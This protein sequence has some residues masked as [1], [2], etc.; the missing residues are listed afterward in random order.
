VLILFLFTGSLPKNL[1]P[2]AAYS[3]GTVSTRA[4]WR[5]HLAAHAHCVLAL[6]MTTRRRWPAVRDHLDHLAALDARWPPADNSVLALF[7][8]YIQGAYFQGTGSLD[9]ALAV[10]SDPR[11]SLLFP[12]QVR[13]LLDIRLLAAFNR[14]WILQHPAHSD[15][16]T[17]ADLVATLAALCDR[18][19]DPEIQTVFHIAHVTSGSTTSTSTTT[20]DMSLSSPP[21]PPAGAS[22]A[23]TTIQ[24]TKAAIHAAIKHAQATNNALHSAMTLC[25]LHAY[26][27]E[28]MVSSQALKSAQAASAQALRAGDPL[29]ISVA[30]R[31]LAQSYDVQGST[32]KAAEHWARSAQFAAE[33]PLGDDL[34]PSIKNEGE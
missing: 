18:H 23:S 14:L 11:F 1:T 7:R 2:P 21:P 10:Y 26:L 20:A 15:P 5:A 13:P 12:K 30:D 16:P 6:F 27:F 33:V 24:S 31:I 4:R 29:W 32:D 8:L 19:P 9:R 17:H 22:S 34:D 25:I 28:G 3:L